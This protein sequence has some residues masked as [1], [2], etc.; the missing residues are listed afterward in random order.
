MSPPVG[1]ALW[2]EV[3]EGGVI[4]DN[5]FVPQGCDVGSSI[6]AVHHNEEYFPD[7]YEFKPD[8]WIVS[9]ENPKDAVEVARS[10]FGPFSLGS[11]GCAGQTMAYM[12]LSNVLAKTIWY[13][14]FRRPEGQLGLVGAGG[15]GK[16]N[17]RHRVGEFQLQDHL[18]S[19][20]EGPFLQFRCRAG[21][22]KELLEL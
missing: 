21:F 13:F 7:S 15:A 20:H 1:A 19:L 14:D 5:V 17:G 6:Y 18:T 9:E 12:E 22:E 16:G 10:A 4:I 11:R 8:R 3:C 2:R